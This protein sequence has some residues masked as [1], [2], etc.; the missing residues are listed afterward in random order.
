[1]NSIKDFLSKLVSQNPGVST[2]R[3]MSLLSLVTA[4]CIAAYGMHKVP[5]DYSGLSLLCGTFL[6]AAFGGKIAQKSQ[7]K[8][9]DA[10]S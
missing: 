9:D 5:I 2:L 6:G 4:I 7:E 8:K 1:M 10:V 3:V